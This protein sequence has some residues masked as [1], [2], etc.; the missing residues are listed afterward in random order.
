MWYE[1]AAGEAA[2]ASAESGVAAA[3][4]AA[5]ATAGGGETDAPAAAASA[6]AAAA[7]TTRHL[8]LAL[9]RFLATVNHFSDF[10][11]D[12]FDFHAYCVRKATLRAYVEMLREAPRLRGKAAAFAAAAVGVRESFFS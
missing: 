8:G 12:A 2:L 6:A 5:T 4:A 11:E 9:K 3:E 7:V 10:D 1:V